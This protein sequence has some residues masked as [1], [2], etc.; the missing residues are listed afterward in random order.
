MAALV[1]IGESKDSWEEFL[2]GLVGRGPRGVQL[3]I[4]DA[5]EGLFGDN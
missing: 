1:A 4:S 2:K 3:A 5:H